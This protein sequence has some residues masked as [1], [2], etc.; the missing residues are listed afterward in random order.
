[1]LAPAA[2]AATASSSVAMS[3]ITGAPNSSRMRR[4]TSSAPKRWPRVVQS[5]AIAEAPASTSARASSKVGVIRIL[6]SSIMRF[7]MPM[8]GRST[9]ARMARMSSGPA[10]RMPAAPPSTAAR[11]KRA[12]E[13]ESRNAS[14]RRAWQET[15]KPPRIFCRNS[16]CV[17]MF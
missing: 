5:I 9:A 15:I 12:M 14:P 8:T 6:P 1:M 17:D 11:A 13:A 7:S 10:A 16:S 2:S 4:T 3:A